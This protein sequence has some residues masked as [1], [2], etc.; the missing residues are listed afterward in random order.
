VYDKKNRQGTHLAEMYIQQ[1]HAQQLN[2]ENRAENH[3]E[4][5]AESL[6][7]NNPT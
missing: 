4:N 5:R 7:K 1:I 3:A 6:P 2:H